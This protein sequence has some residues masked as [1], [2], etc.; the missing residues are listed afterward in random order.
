[1]NSLSDKI[2]SGPTYIDDVLEELQ[3]QRRAE[4]ALEGSDHEVELL[5]HH[6][7]ELDA[8]HLL[9]SRLLT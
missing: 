2:S 7:G 8:V 1:M 5:L 6:V 4:V 9:A 3:G